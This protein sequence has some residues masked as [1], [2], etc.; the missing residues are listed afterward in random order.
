MYKDYRKFDIFDIA[1]IVVGFIGASA[2][3]FAVSSIPK[4]YDASKLC[5]ENGYTQSEWFL[6]GSIYCARK[7]D[8]GRDEVVRIK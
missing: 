1:L 6:D 4:S 8:L 7:G 5:H 2:I 3:I